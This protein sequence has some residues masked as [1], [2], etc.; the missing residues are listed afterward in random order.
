VADLLERS[1]DDAR[2]EAQLRYD[3]ANMVT[4]REGDSVS[5]ALLGAGIIATC[6]SAKYRRPRG[7]Y[8]LCGDCGSCLVRIDGKPNVRACMTKV[9]PGMQVAPQN[10]VGAAGFDPTGLVDHVMGGGVDH[11]HMMVRPRLANLAMQKVA[12]RLTGIGTLPDRSAEQKAA[13]TLHRPDVLVVGQGNAGRAA[14]EI[15][16]DAGVHAIAVER[17]VDVPSS[18]QVLTSTGLFGAYPGENVLAAAQGSTQGPTTLHEFRP[19]H[20]IVATGARDPMIPLANN[21]LPG[22]VAA[23]GLLEQLDRAQAR[24]AV[25]CVVI[26][27]GENAER[28]ATKLGAQLVDP[29]RVLRILGGS[30]VEG[31]KHKGGT[32]SCAIVA[33]APTPSPCH[34]VARQAGT[35][36][37]WNGAGFA[38]ETDLHGRC[39]PDV[40]VIQPA[41]ATWAC[42]DVTGFKGPEAAAEDGRRVA[43]A[44]LERLGGGQNA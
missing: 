12:R 28:C 44:V 33:L 41:F 32:T 37:K 18:G 43:K 16:A 24:L 13:L 26:G 3:D 19:R 30:R 40:E 2:P 1:P 34:E 10:L 36:V 14:L 6:R 27:E 25:S 31:V 29:Q 23:R 15:L 4:A 17:H 42:G 35:R 8:C 5:I 20:V 7:P 11:H 21:D 38:V 39:V 9:R 22:V